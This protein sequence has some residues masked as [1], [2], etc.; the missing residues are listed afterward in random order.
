MKIVIY[1][2]VAGIP[3]SQ[4]GLSLAFLSRACK[5]PDKHER[6]AARYIGILGYNIPSAIFGDRDRILDQ[7][8][9][10]YDTI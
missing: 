10:Q 3:N 8:D 9:I 6:Q 5:G 2:S 7:R 4:L 1:S